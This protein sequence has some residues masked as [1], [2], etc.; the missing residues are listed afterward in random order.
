MT[1]QKQ[2]EAEHAD[3]LEGLE[4][5]QRLPVTWA[6]GLCANRYA[7]MLPC[8][9]ATLHV[10]V[11]SVCVM[12]ASGAICLPCNGHHREPDRPTSLPEAITTPTV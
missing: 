10:L 2:N 6:L 7:S 5:A 1:K 12:T 4:L 11:T 8:L 3:G 9:A